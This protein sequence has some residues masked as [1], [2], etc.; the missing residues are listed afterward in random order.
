MS[1]SS[2]VVLTMATP[3]LVFFTDFWPQIGGEHETSSRFSPPYI[4]ILI[5]TIF[6]ISLTIS[7]NYPLRTFS[8]GK[9][10]P[11]ETQAS[12]SRN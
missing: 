10:P 1:V 9:I 2:V 5:M 12:K 7:I 11:D 3:T 8:A 6:A 4:V